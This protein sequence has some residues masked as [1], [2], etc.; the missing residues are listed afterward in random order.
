[1]GNTR[2]RDKRFP[3]CPP[4]VG[5]LIR[6]SA[7]GGFLYFANQNQR[8]L[9][10]FERVVGRQY[11]PHLSAYGYF[12]GTIHVRTDNPAYVERFNY[13]KAEWIR[14]INVEMGVDIISDMRIKVLPKGEASGEV[15]E[16]PG[17]RD[18]ANDIK[19]SGR[20]DPE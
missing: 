8:I 15:P 11:A 5:D 12:M 16:D 1:M 3:G 4:S 19:K 20:D 2:G 14:A 18:M 10:L 13:L 6:K 7:N 17:Y 9:S